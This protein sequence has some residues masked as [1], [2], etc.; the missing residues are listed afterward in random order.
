MGD[1]VSAAG[2]YS[3]PRD[4]GLLRYWD[5]SAWSE[6]TARLTT[7]LEE[8]DLGARVR[9]LHAEY[10]QLRTQVVQTADV[11]IL[12]EVGIY[13]Y[14]H[15]LDDAPA[16][17]VL[18]ERIEE[19]LRTSVKSGAAVTS[20]KKWIINGSE[21][22]GAKMVADFSKLIL[23][24]YNNE[25]DNVVRT[26]RPYGVD[27]AI[28]RLDKLRASIA[29]LGASM[30]LA[31]TDE[32]HALRV[33]EIRLTADYLHKLAEQKE[34][35]R[36]ERVRL[37]EEA[38][39]RREYEAEQARLEKEQQHY[40]NALAK[41][42]EKGDVAAVAETQARLNQVQEALDG[43]I[44]R[45]ANIRAGYV[46]VISNVGAFGPRVV[47]IGLTRRLQP[48]ERVH[49]LGGASVPFRFDL[50]ALIFSDDAV[51]LETALHREFAA[52]RVNLI[53]VRREFFYIEP[54]EVKAALIRLNGDLLT[55][56]DVPHAIEWRQ[57]ESLRR[58]GSPRSEPHDA[59][60][61]RGVEVDRLDE[62]DDDREP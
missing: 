53:N 28:A 43:V 14:S 27:A 45:A 38:L 13:Q 36:E 16:F 34:H 8:D 62:L 17:K 24:A 59:G 5:G 26:L 31:V 21:K 33:S 57:S 39:A 42:A 7:S 20:T 35:E 10:E 29:K 54:G 51:S 22:E 15:P 55:F 50:H 32:Y 11:M 4:A 12:Q 52:H 19:E 49:E 37:R 18:L 46:Y 9:A 41:L 48:L 6:R 40:L 3:D 47:K 23:R 44:A 2:W 56:F 25:A 30:K 60:G 58:G 61:A 1:D